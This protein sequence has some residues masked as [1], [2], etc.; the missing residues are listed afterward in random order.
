[1]AI[2]NIAVCN[3]RFMITTY[4]NYN[5]SICSLHVCVEGTLTVCTVSTDS[6]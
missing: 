1:M 4:T 2:H 6:N 5:W 3:N